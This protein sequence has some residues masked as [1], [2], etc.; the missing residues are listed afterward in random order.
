MAE[1]S[2]YIWYVDLS[3]VTAL[4]ASGCTRVYIKAGGDGAG[5]VWS[6]WSA[7]TLQPFTAAGIQC[8]PWFFIQRA[9][10]TDMQTIMR[11]LTQL[12][13]PEV[14]LNVEIG[15]GGWDGASYADAAACVAAARLAAPGRKVG[16]SSCP[17]WDGDTTRGA[18]YFPYEGFAANCD[19]AMPQ[20][21]WTGPPDQVA[22]ETRRN[23]HCPV[24]P[25]LWG[26]WD[27]ADLVRQEQHCEQVLG[28]QYAGISGWE[29]GNAAYNLAG[30]REAYAAEPVVITAEE[31]VTVDERTQ[32]L[33]DTGAV[34]FFARGNLTREGV[35]NL[36][37]YGGS[38]AER[39]A[40]YEKARYHRLNGHT[41][42]F[43]VEGPV[44][45]E[46][47]QAAGKITLYG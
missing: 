19:Y 34:P 25:I 43:F 46:A 42:A 3:R 7:A 15:E 13:A 29:A 47:L 6:Q 40:I 23:P 14:V 9:Y 24:V 28:A 41:Y 30:M 5:R 33:A 10:G 26:L 38:G 17:S 36:S 1:K 22:Y 2:A 18:P 21:Y 12:N 37:A 11:A 35:A 39:I 16:F 44:S 4:A 31:T 27:T 8:I 32:L 20:Q 45:Y